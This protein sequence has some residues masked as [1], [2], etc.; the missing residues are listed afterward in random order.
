MKTQLR[1][2]ARSLPEPLKRPLRWCRDRLVRPAP[3]RDKHEAELSFWD[4][5]VA[6]TGPEA[7]T[8][9]YQRFM[10]AMGNISDAGFFKDKVCLDIGCGPKGSLTWL[11]DARAAIGIDP[12]AEQYRRFGIDRH[13]M[14]YLACGVESIPLTTAYADV[15]FS[16]NSLDHVDDLPRACAEIRRVLGP[17]GHFIASLNLDEPPTVEEP[18]TLTESWLAEH[19]FRGWEQEY[20]AVRPRLDDPRHFGPYRY[21][22]EPV[23][24]ELENWSGPRALWCRFRVPDVSA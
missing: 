19:L 15:I 10:L 24:E 23:P 20:Y 18:W 17:G 12:L 11:R 4:D 16:M 2:L 7:E 21:F 13:P 14:L 22:F 5:Y 1:A 8:E 9:Y 6:Q 3:P